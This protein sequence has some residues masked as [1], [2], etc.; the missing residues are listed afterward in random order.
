MTRVSSKGWVGA[1]LLIMVLASCSTVTDAVLG[2]AEK[3]V[4]RAVSKKVED[5]VYKRVASSAKL[6]APQTAQW[7]RFMVAQAQVIFAYSFSVSGYWPGQRG[8]EAGEYTVF[9][10]TDDE[11]SPVE[12]E[13]AYLKRSDDGRQWWR[14]AWKDEEEN[15]VYEGLLDLQEERLVRLRAKDP[16]GNVDEIPVTEE[17][18]VYVAPTGVTEESL[19]GATV[20]TQRLK[21]QIGR[22]SCRE[23]VCHRV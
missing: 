2:G 16:E 1:I 9:E 19:Q 6:P 10:W 17:D 8:Y 21:T 14:V 13:K 20:D 23:R 3:G 5:A 11:G 12:L 4:E 18:Q 15:W 22:A 7:N